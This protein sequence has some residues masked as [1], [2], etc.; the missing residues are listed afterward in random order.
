MSGQLSVTDA[1]QLAGHDIAGAA[2]LCDQ[3]CQ[4]ASQHGIRCCRGL[5]GAFSACTPHDQL[6][7]KL[8]AWQ[9]HSLLCDL[10]ILQHTLSWRSCSQHT[11]P[12][13]ELPWDAAAEALRSLADELRA[14]CSC[15]GV[16][17][18]SQ[19]SFTLMI[20]DLP[21]PW[22]LIRTLSFLWGADAEALQDMADGLEGELAPLS[23]DEESIQNGLDSRD[24]PDA[25]AE[26][27]AQRLK[28][29]AKAG[30]FGQ[31]VCSLWGR[32]GGPKS[33]CSR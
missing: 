10:P 33:L 2:L 1:L 20:P 9:Q 16:S 28:Q 24:D 17:K 11:V 4:M 18:G 14:T 30:G 6:H 3:P 5:A 15:H 23:T 8:L 21:A 7:P 31:P 13:A 32:A 26:T 19:L 25:A 22:S 27:E 12:K 29:E